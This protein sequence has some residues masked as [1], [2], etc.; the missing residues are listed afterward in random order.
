MKT[1]Q[2]RRAVDDR[3]VFSARLKALSARRPARI[4]APF[5]KPHLILSSSSLFR[6]SSYSSSV[7]D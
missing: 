3:C 4:P 6:I 7:D 5:S 1:C 2:W